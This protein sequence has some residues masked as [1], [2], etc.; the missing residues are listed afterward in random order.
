MEAYASFLYASPLRP[1][2]RTLRPGFRGLRCNLATSYPPQRQSGHY[3]MSEDEVLKEGSG[4][5]G[6]STS[7]RHGSYGVLKMALGRLAR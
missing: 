4:A 5:R 6:L 1:F 2:R 3:V 7:S